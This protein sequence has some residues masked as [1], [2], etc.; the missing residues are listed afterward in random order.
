LLLY[1]SVGG[2]AQTVTRAAR[3]LALLV[4]SRVD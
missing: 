3:Q 4:L 2:D 1:L